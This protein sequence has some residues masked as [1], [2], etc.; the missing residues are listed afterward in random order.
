LGDFLGRVT[1]IHVAVIRMSFISAPS[2]QRRGEPRIINVTAESAAE[3]PRV[4]ALIHEVRTQADVFVFLAGGAS[5]MQMPEEN[6]RKLLRIF[7]ALGI[8]AQSGTRLAVGDGGTQAGIMEAAGLAR[9]ASGFVFSLT[10][11][12][13]ANEIAPGGQTAVDLHH[14]HVVAVENRA[15]DGSDGWWGSETATMYELFARLAE[16]RPSVTIVA[17]GGSI[18]LNEVDENIRAERPMIVIAGSGRAADAL[19]SLLADTNPI[20]GEV[21]E[22]RTRAAELGLTRRPELLHIFNLADSSPRDL[23]RTLTDVL[24]LDTDI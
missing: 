22:L 23:A 8:L 24:L 21:A 5:K 15:W 18:T 6:T 16:G 14:G 20:E 9:E 19:V 4:R 17:N 7:D 1:P 10:G 2:A 12:A 3:D 13:P 11:V